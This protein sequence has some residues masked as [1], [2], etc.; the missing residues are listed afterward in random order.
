[1]LY[2]LKVSYRENGKVV[3]K[4]HHFDTEREAREAAKNVDVPWDK[5]QVWLG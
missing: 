2:I 4:V 3:D 5:L 1:M